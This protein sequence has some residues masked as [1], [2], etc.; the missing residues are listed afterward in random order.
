[1]GV[2]S[3]RKK[4]TFFFSSLGPTPTQL[5]IEFGA[6]GHSS[7]PIIITP[8]N[9]HHKKRCYPPP[10]IKNI[11]SYTAPGS[12][13]TAIISLVLNHEI[14]SI[15]SAPTVLVGVHKINSRHIV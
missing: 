12:I 15:M 4:H 9:D 6:S 3:L 2:D 5:F 8:E 14:C 1:M 10:K 11:N 7:Q 13:S